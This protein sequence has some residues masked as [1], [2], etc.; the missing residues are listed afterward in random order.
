MFSLWRDYSKK[1]N[2]IEIYR[3]FSYES[4]FKYEW[5]NLPNKRVKTMLYKLYKLGVRRECA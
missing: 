4:L 1:G 5:R 3:A 2:R